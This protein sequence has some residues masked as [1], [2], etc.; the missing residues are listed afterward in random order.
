MARLPAQLRADPGGI[1]CIAPA[2]GATSGEQAVEGAADRLHHLLVGA[3]PGC[4]FEPDP[5]TQVLRPSCPWVAASSRASTQTWAYACTKLVNV[6][7]GQG[8][9]RW[10][11]FFRIWMRR[12]PGGGWGLT[13]KQF[14]KPPLAVLLA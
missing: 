2:V 3:F 6:G 13:A 9:L 5:P 14:W 4:P 12:F 11:E 8:C 1:D 10:M 7:I